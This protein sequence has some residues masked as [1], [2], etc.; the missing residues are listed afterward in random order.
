MRS[1]VPMRYELKPESLIQQLLHYHST[2]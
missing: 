2:D 1:K